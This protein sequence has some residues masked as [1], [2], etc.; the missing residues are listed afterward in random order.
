MITG[1]ELHGGDASPACAFST[2]DDAETIP[3]SPVKQRPWFMSI[4]LATRPRCFGCGGRLLPKVVV[5]QA[6]FALCE[7]CASTPW[8]DYHRF[9]LA[10][11]SLG[12]PLELRHTRGVTFWVPPSDLP[13][14]DGYLRWM[15]LWETRTGTSA[16]RILRY[17]GPECRSLPVA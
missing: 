1:F 6:D 13:D 16:R 14:Q 2:S 15:Q 11:E 4:S 9:W 10:I 8:S 17:L 5:F 7:R 3:G 12:K